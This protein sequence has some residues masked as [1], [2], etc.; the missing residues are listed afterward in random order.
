MATKEEVL[1]YLWDKLTSRGLQELYPYAA[2]IIALESNF[3]AG[4]VGTGAPG[5]RSIGL[6]QINMGSGL[7]ASRA[8]MFFETDDVE[9]AVAQLRDWKTNI[10]IAVDRFMLPNY[11][12]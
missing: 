12:A 4:A 9:Q 5:E 2:Q 7:G 8:R 3:A 6:F 1:Q 10:D 11:Q